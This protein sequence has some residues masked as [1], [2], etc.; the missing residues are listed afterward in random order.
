MPDAP[1]L[2]WALTWRTTSDSAAIRALVDTAAE[3]GPIRLWHCENRPLSKRE[4]DFGVTDVESALPAAGIG[5]RGWRAGSVPR[6][7]NSPLAAALAGLAVPPYRPGSW[8]IWPDPPAA[9]RPPLMRRL[10]S[11]ANRPYLSLIRFP[12]LRRRRG[13]RRRGPG[14]FVRVASEW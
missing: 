2:Q 9:T 3:L 10:L 13:D 1:E 7:A 5:R 11:S 6:A 14:Q 12:I 4:A 8:T